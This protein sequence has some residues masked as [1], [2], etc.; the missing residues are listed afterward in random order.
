MFFVTQYYHM[1]TRRFIGIVASI[2]L[3]AGGAG[4]T[5]AL[6]GSV[7]Y[8]VDINTTGGAGQSGFLD[9]QLATAAPPATASVT[10]TIADYSSN[11]TAGPVTFTAGDVS[12]SFSST[13]LVLANDNAASSIPGLSALQ[14][15]G[16]A[17]TFLSFRL[18][19]AGSEVNGGSGVPF[20]GTVFSFV[21]EDSNQTGLNTGPLL[22]EAF[23]IYV[24]PGGSVT[25]APNDPYVAGGPVPGYAPASG[26]YPQVIIS[27]VAIP[28]PSSIVLL[29]IGAVAVAVAGCRRKRRA[30]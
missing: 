3:L 30:A 28:E 14:Q 22:G 10:V 26:Q 1:I 6:A 7:S 20:T 9:A 15:M 29:S 11:A 19:V 4:V 2:G 5:E 8:Q 13:P 21:L 27:P 17:G 24:N 16:T 18:T 12:G 25:V 23:D